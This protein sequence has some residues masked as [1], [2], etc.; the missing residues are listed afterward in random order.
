VITLHPNGVG[1]MIRPFPSRSSNSVC[2]E[3][4]GPPVGL[5]R[6]HRHRREPHRARGWTEP[7]PGLHGPSC[8][9]GGRGCGAARWPGSSARSPR[10]PPPSTRPAPLRAPASPHRCVR[11]GRPNEPDHPGG[12]RRRAGR[13]MCGWRR[14]RAHRVVA[15]AR[16]P[17]RTPAGG[18]PDERHRPAVATGR[19]T[20]SQICPVTRPPGMA[21]RSG[22]DRAAGATGPAPAYRYRGDAGTGDR[23]AGAGPLPVRARSPVPPAAYLAVPV[24][25]GARPVPVPG[26]GC[27]L[28]DPPLCD[29]RF[30]C[31][32]RCRNGAS[33]KR[34]PK[35]APA[36]SAS[37]ARGLC[38]GSTR[39]PPSRRPPPQDPAWQGPSDGGSCRG[40][41]DLTA[42]VPAS[43]P[44]GWVP[45]WPPVGYNPAGWVPGT[46]PPNQLG[47][48][49]DPVW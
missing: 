23:A 36:M 28:R 30:P 47:A 2:G 11:I 35:R 6:A 25:R 46:D 31:H 14:R 20:Q 48:G 43:Y 44:T 3:L 9:L 17:R 37:T 19:N 29:R 39:G 26:P 8:R 34:G 21:P 10:S 13:V 40:P 15:L 18:D 12:P 5:L 41:A 4:A 42:A 27:P 1:R 49:R 16:V 24:R 45:N 7:G 38:G 32:P 22:T 33:A